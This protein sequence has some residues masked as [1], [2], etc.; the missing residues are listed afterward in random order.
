MPKGIYVRKVLI[1][2]CH[3]DREHH[4]KG[5]CRNCYE[6]TYLVESRSKLHKKYWKDN[7][8]EL[9][10]RKQNGRLLK[11][12]WTPESVEKAKKEQNNCCA[13]CSK[14][15]IRTPHADHKHAIPPIP[16]G[17]LCSSCNQALGLFQ[18]SSVIL[19]IAAQYIE[20]YKNSE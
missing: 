5:L 19:R 7:K 20:K 18:D 14:E 17:L 12:G 4:A 13:I 2:T 8:V 16:R 11:L 15:F 1:P 6:K 10:K 9:Y 3:P